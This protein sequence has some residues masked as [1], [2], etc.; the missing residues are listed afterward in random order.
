MN[1]LSSLGPFRFCPL[2]AG[3]LTVTHVEPT[4]R[5]FCEPCQR[6]YYHNPVPAA[7]GVVEED[8]RVLLV[9]RKFPPKV[10]A[11]T[12]PAGFL[13]YRETP[14]ACAEREVAE[15]TGLL[16]TVESLF[17][18]YAGHDDPRQTAVLI[19]YR[20]TV[21]GGRLAPGDDASEAKFFAPNEAP[22]EIAFR[23]HR[24]A[25]EDLLRSRAQGPRELER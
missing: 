22:Q 9:R 15:E 6:V 21:K 19:L 16:A 10:G 5:R 23:A 2:C 17:G 11:W 18:V 13:E 1:D 24:E 4:P 8:G 25:L 3:P 12:L 14:T 7:G 20:M